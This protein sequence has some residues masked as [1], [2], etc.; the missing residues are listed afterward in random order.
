MFKKTIEF[1]GF[2]GEKKVKDFYFHMSKAEL[3]AL[4]ANGNEL[5]ARLQRIVATKDM[6]AIL[7]EFRELIKMACGVRSEDGER[8]LKTPEAQS[9]LLD[10]PAFDVLLMELCTIPDASVQFVQQLIPQ[11]MQDEML[12][13]AQANAPKA[14][15]PFVET[16]RRTHSSD[17]NRPAWL[18]ENRT[19]T[20]AEVMAMTPEEL[21]QAFRNS[22]K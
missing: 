9:E 15:D 19:P 14:V 11:K 16:D 21:H 20:Q 7:S 6:T 13:Q 3:L 4:A 2:D 5:S 22:G 12:A 17:D 8:F 18:K 10:S 1:E